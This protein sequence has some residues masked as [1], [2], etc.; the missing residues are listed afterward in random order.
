MKY[1][2][3]VLLTGA[4][5]NIAAGLKCADSKVLSRY[6]VSQHAAKGK[7]TESTPPSE[8]TDFWWI[9]LCEEHSEPVPDKCK[10]D[11]MFCHRQQVKLDDGK[12]YVTQVFDVPR[13]QEVD[14]EELRDGFQVSFTG[15]W[16]ERER[17]VKVRYT[18]ADDKA[19]DEVSAEGAFGAHTTPVEVALR[20]PS[21]CIQATEKSSGIG[22]WI[23]WLVIYAVLLTLIYLLAKSYMSVG[24]GSMQDFREEFVERSTNLVSSLPEFAKEVMGKVVGGGPSSRGGYSAV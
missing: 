11:A 21:G 6:K 15:K 20:G 4:L 1:V 16:G 22:G 17:K 9:N 12:E 10:D 18:C 8:T 7:F 23:T 5:F 2:R 14:V 3:C 19:E 13:N 24:H